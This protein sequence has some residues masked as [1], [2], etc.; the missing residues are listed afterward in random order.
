MEKLSE[1]QREQDNKT[2]EI[3]LPTNGPILYLFQERKKTIRW[4]NREHDLKLFFFYFIFCH[5]QSLSTLSYCLFTHIR[6]DFAFYFLT[7]K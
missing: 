6:N 3:I 4:K 5:A 1:R 7:H 2:N